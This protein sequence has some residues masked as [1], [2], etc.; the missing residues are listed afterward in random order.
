MNFYFLVEDSKSLLKV[1]PS[2]LGY[3]GFPCERVDRV[4]SI[5]NNCYI[6]QS[7]HGCYQLVD[8]VLEEVLIDINQNSAKINALIILID[9]ENLTVD[10]RLLNIQNKIS[11]LNHKYNVEYPII[12]FVVDCCFETWLLGNRDLFP[13]QSPESTSPFF[14]YYNFYD[15]SVNN[16]ELM[17]ADENNPQYP[18]YHFHSKADFHFRYFHELCRHN[19]IRYS[20]NNP[21]AVNKFE[22]FEKIVQR[23]NTTDHLNSFRKFYE[24]INSLS[25]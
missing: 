25:Q 21:K 19:R 6:L 17:P 13:S 16:P 11:S 2:W 10:E 15:V 22:F 3:M 24:Y 9:S 1:L 23:I 8:K 20:K 14:P 4:S 7:G 12:P 5:T 18:D